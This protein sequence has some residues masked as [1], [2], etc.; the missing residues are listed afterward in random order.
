MV[1]I[2]T[3]FETYNRAIL[4]KYLV[5]L[6]L[7]DVFWNFVHEHLALLW[8]IP[9]VLFEPKRPALLTFDFEISNFFAHLNIILVGSARDFHESLE[10]QFLYVSV[11]N[12]DFVEDN[13]GLFLHD[14]G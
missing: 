7:G 10:K 1:S 14:S 13:T 12:W 11:Y 8:L 2:E 3:Q 9:D 4:L 6:R 5:Q